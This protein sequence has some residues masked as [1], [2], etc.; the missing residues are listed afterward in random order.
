MAVKR[1]PIANNS[2][3]KDEVAK[4]A[5]DIGKERVALALVAR[6]LGLSIAVKLAYGTYP[7][8]PKNLIAKALNEFITAYKSGDFEKDRKL[9]KKQSR[10]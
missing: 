7:S 9:H 3:L 10:S 2:N 1:M 4:A 5:E 6:G 8:E